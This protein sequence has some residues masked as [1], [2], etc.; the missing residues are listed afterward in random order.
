MPALAPVWR[1][2]ARVFELRGNTGE[3]ARAAKNAR[4]LAG[5][6][7]RGF[8]YG[9]GDGFHLNG[10]RFMLVLEGDGLALYRPAR[11]RRPEMISIMLMRSGLPSP[12]GTTVSSPFSATSKHPVPQLRAP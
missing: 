1:N 3:A 9:V 5:R 12:W 6:A 11:A 7:P 2:L 8:P 4:Q 10:Q